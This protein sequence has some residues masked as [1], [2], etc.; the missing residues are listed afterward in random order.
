MAGELKLGRD[1]LLERDGRERLIRS[2]RDDACLGRQHRGIPRGLV[3]VARC[4]DRAAGRADDRLRARVDLRARVGRQR[5]KQVRE[6]ADAVDER[7]VGPAEPDAR[8]IRRREVV[9]VDQ[10]VLAERAAEVDRSCGGV[11]DVGRVRPR[12]ARAAGIFP[13]DQHG[14]CVRRERDRAAEIDARRRIR[15]GQRRG[16]RAESGRAHRRRP[17]VTS[18]NKSGPWQFRREFSAS[19]RG[20]P[21][22]IGVRVE[23]VDALRGGR[24]RTVLGRRKFVGHERE[25]APRRFDHHADG[26]DRRVLTDLKIIPA[27]ASRLALDRRVPSGRGRRQLRVDAIDEVLLRLPERLGRR[28]EADQRGVEVRQHRARP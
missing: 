16:L 18:R 4:D 26:I 9:L 23:V 5:L 10:P 20:E 19:G 24:G 12:D 13:V 2:V 3:D 6:V 25:V 7:R 22:V 1:E 8:Q 28:W 14:R 15:R 17:K 21:I 27:V 11:D